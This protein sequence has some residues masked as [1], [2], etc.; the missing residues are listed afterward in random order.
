M[1]TKYFVK[2]GFFGKNKYKLPEEFVD[3]CEVDN[4]GLTGFYAKETP[5]KIV[6]TSK[7]PEVSESELLLKDAV[8]TVP[9]GEASGLFRL[10]GENDA[11]FYKSKGA[12]GKNIFT[13]QTFTDYVKEK[14]PELCGKGTSKEISLISVRQLTAYPV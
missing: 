12:A 8:T 1:W 7:I 10:P 2:K 3:N 5:G 4:N 11:I 9:Y 6:L 14:Y 13:D